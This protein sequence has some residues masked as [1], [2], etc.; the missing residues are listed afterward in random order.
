MTTFEQISSLGH[1][2][3][4]AGECRALAVGGAGQ[5]FVRRG[6]GLHREEESLYGEVQYIMSNGH[7]G[8]P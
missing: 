7:N 3:S 1:Q 8:P 2:M 4:L 6:L 5:H